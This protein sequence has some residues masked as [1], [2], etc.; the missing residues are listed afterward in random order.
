MIEID[1]IAAEGDGYRHWSWAEL[2]LLLVLTRLLVLQ[3]LENLRASVLE[4]GAD[5]DF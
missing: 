4:G 5:R 3:L 1:P 2:R